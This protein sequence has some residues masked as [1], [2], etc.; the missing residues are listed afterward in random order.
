MEGLG[1]NENF[2]WKRTTRPRTRVYT[3]DTPRIAAGE[4][5]DNLVDMSF[6]IFFLTYLYIFFHV[7]VYF[8]PL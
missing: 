6:K 3:H 5:W 4:L 8:L 7:F 2:H 1:F